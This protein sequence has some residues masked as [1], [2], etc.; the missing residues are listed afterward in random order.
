MKKYL[1][2]ILI[3]AAFVGQSLWLYEV[4]RKSASNTQRIDRDIERVDAKP[5]SPIPASAINAAVIDKVA[6]AEVRLNRAINDL[7]ERTMLVDGQL[8]DFMH[9]LDN[10]LTSTD[11]F[12]SY[13]LRDAGI[14]IGQYSNEL[15][16]RDNEEPIPCPKPGEAHVILTLGQSHMSNVAEAPQIEVPDA[17]N[18]SWWDGKCYSAKDPLVGTDGR[19][20]NVVTRIARDLIKNGTFKHVLLVPISIGSSR[21]ER[22]APGGD[23]H[24]KIP[25]VIWQLLKNNL[26]PDT[27]IWWQGAGN[28]NDDDPGGERYRANLSAVVKSLRADAP[29]ANIYVTLSTTCGPIKTRAEWTRAA[30][31]AVAASG[32]GIFQGPDVDRLGPEFRDS[33]ACHL[34]E[35]GADAAAAEYAEVIARRRE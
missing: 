30:Q 27:I 22:W 10:R 11:I 4:Q 12:T 13:R 6:E 5:P 15:L 16:R 8:S 31:R 21:V 9:E 20:A 2:G 14:V 26:A 19:M 34:N 33:L 17:V 25:V 35:R 23:L 29:K 7:S 24:H 32:P 28:S 1:T 18:F 3:A